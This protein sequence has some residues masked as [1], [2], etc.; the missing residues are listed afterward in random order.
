MEKVSREMKE[1]FFDLVFTQDFK[2]PAFFPL[3]S[4][5]I[6]FRSMNDFPWDLMMT[7]NGGK[8]IILLAWGLKVKILRKKFARFFTD[9]R[10]SY[11]H[12]GKFS[13]Y[14]C[15]SI[16]SSRARGSSVFIKSDYKSLRGQKQ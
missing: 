16:S 6:S 14:S 5:Q 2:R 3:G 9:Q 10:L 12:G 15:S 13:N 8:K 1:M 7:K 4:W 11:M